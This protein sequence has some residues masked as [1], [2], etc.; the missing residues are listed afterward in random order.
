MEP[1]FYKNVQNFDTITPS[2]TGAI[3]SF[4]FRYGVSFIYLYQ[5]ISKFM[6]KSYLS[7][8]FI[9]NFKVA[10]PSIF[11]NICI[12][13]Q[14]IPFIINTFLN[15]IPHL[16]IILYAFYAS[17]QFTIFI[18][19]IM[20]YDKF[21][22]PFAKC[23]GLMEWYKYTKV[24]LELCLLLFN[25]FIYLCVTNILTNTMLRRF[26]SQPKAMT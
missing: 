1:N 6:Y 4:Y 21:L 13:C 25:Y 3:V 18:S 26:V 10:I 19:Y 11:L 14:I 5:M 16:Y 2:H 20:I 8:L 24:C 23:G 17:C 12:N 15:K 9:T 22:K 7:N